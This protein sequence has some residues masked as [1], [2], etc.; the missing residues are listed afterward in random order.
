MPDDGRVH[1]DVE[2]LRGERA[3]CRDREAQDVP[4]VR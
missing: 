2:R 3:K 1:Q 4:V